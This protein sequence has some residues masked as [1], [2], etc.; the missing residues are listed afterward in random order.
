MY[1]GLRS[2]TEKAT[3]IRLVLVG[4]VV[5]CVCAGSDVAFYIHYLRLLI[6]LQRS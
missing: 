6:L 4:A 1:P 2:G 3:H 5:C